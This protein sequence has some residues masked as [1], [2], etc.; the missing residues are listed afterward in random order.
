MNGRLFWVVA[1]LLSATP[2]W[3]Q[4]FLLVKDIAALENK[5]H[6]ASK[7][8]TTIQCSFSQEKNISLLTEKSIAKGKFYFKRESKV[9]L[10]YQQPI[11]N[12]IV[13]D[14]S[15]LVLKE[16]KKITEM[17]VNKSRVFR[18]LNSIIIGSI[19]GSLFSS[20][21]F[22]VQLLENSTLVKAELK[23]TAK[24]LK[25]FISSIVILLDKKD[26]TATRIEMNETSGDNTILTFSNKVINGEVNDSL[27]AVK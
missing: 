26:F 20:K 3:A 25:K 2:I 24:M 17:D 21:E 8:T 11:K 19:N 1:L 14:G 15:R 7:K 9:M 22:S 12:Q 4:S 13:M 16:G 18:Q 10:D 5:L 23:P 27:F 6:E